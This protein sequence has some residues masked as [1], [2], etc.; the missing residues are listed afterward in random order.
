MI[1]ILS[2]KKKKK[3]KKK[4]RE[5]LYK[6]TSYAMYNKVRQKIYIHIYIYTQYSINKY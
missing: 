2:L 4:M 3:K 6:D 5:R 1:R